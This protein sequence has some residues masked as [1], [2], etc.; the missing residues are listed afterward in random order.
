MDNRTANVTNNAGGVIAWP[1]QPIAEQTAARL[2]EI[3]M[4]ICSR[5]TSTE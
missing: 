5:L 2:S 1:A 4:M 3:E